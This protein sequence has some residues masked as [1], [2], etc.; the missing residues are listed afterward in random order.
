MPLNEQVI[1]EAVDRYWREIDRYSK[2]AA[3]VANKCQQIVRT[4]VLRATVQWRPKDKD[5]FEK[6]LKRYMA[7]PAERETLHTVDD[8]FRR[9]GDLA[10]VRVTTYVE[11]DR[12]KIVAEIR[13]HFDG[14]EAN[15]EVLVDKKDKAGS[16]YRATHCQVMLR[17]DELV[18]QY[19]N[20]DGLSCEIQVCSLLAHVWNEIEHDLGYK[21]L[22][23][24]LSLTEKES[25]EALGHQLKAGD[26]TITQLLKATEQRLEHLKGKFVDEYDFVAR[27]RGKFKDTPEFGLNASQLL[28]ELQAQGLDTPEK[29]EMDLL[30]GNYEQRSLDL[31]NSY[32]RKWAGE[33]VVADPVVGS[34]DHL[35]MLL[36]EKHDGDVLKRHPTGRGMGRPSRIVSIAKRFAEVKPKASG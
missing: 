32:L 16:F 12:D 9:V 4:N 18:G 13:K 30:T 23:G 31:L 20:L 25:L 26:T 34:S 33:D 22:T 28:S 19:A 21:P 10:G 3:F 2:L 17:K 1:K 6:K 24:K 7:E 27:V 36:L 35:L 15:N 8:V 11:T 5:G 29:I 14:P